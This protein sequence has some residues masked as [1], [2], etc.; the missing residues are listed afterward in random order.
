VKAKKSAIFSLSLH[1]HQVTKDLS[2][3]RDDSYDN[4]TAIQGTFF[5]VATFF[6]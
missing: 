5:L 3:I 2:K 6:W 1:T 4:G